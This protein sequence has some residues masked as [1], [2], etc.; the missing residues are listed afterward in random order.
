MKKY[1]LCIAVIAM[2]LFSCQN[3][4]TEKQNE[5]NVKP[6]V[7]QNQTTD[8]SVDSKGNAS[9]LNLKILDENFELFPI[10]EE[11]FDSIKQIDI[12]EL[13]K[14]FLD[15]ANVER[16]EQNLIYALE[17][18]ENFTLKN[19]TFEDYGSDVEHY[20]HI[21]S[22]ENIPYWFGEISYYEGGGYYMLNKKNGDFKLLG[23]IPVVSPDNK[24]IV[25]Y[26]CDIEAGYMFNG[27]EL[28][29]VSVDSLQLLASC[30]L[31]DWGPMSIKWINNKS[32]AIE[33]FGSVAKDVCFETDYVKVKL[34]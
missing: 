25:T 8:S 1:S 11:Q 29:S 6:E 5:N 3:G 18:G 17:N 22:Y 23:G 21:K 16:K 15:D 33:R 12:I 34:F 9:L 31:N 14:E 7:L 10:S 28:L 4:K 26:S 19:K 20:R 13:G 24:Y 2:S 32:I 27:L 30:P